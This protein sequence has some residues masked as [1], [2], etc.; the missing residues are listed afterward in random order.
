MENL[1]LSQEFIFL[2]LND[3]GKIS[4]IDE[5]ARTCV[6]ASAIFEMQLEE[7]LEIEDKRVVILKELPEEMNYLSSLYDFL[8]ESKKPRRFSDIVTNYVQSFTDKRIL[9]LTHDICNTLLEKGYVNFE[10]KGAFDSMNKYIPI[11][12]K[13]EESIAI[14]KSKLLENKELDIESIILANLLD[15]ANKLKQYF[16]NCERKDL[17]ETLKEA[18]KSEENKHIARA[19]SAIDDTWMIFFVATIY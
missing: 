4:S 19:L 16:S 2:T 5:Y 1:S 18:R 10:E 17:K 7:I 14:M 3:K 8:R 11:K 12:S 6:I 9:A 15:K 13:Q